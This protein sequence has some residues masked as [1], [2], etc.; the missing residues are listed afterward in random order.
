MPAVRREHVEKP[1]R[2]PR[3]V[4]LLEP[5]D[6]GRAEEGADPLVV[7]HAD[8]VAQSGGEVRCEALGMARLCKPRG[9]T[10]RRIELRQLGEH[11]F[12]AEKVRADEGREVLAD[13]VLVARDDRRVRDRQSERVA[14]ERHDREPVRDRADHRG[15]RECRHIAPRRMK[16][17]QRRGRKV[18]K[19]G[20]GEEAECDRL[21]TGKA[22]RS[23]RRAS[24]CHSKRQELS[25]KR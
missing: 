20:R 16:R 1:A 14:E 12:G 10:R 7:E 17:D 2:Q 19:P 11:L 23:R 13:P 6:N 15:L 5:G 9:E 8:G 21:H 4:D 24:D 22:E 25:V 18:D 3:D